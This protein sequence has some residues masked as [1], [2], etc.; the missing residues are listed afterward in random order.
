VNAAQAPA[1]ALE[2]ADS[3]LFVRAYM[4]FGSH[5]SMKPSFPLE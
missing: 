3:D 1:Q 5:E 2:A 4:L